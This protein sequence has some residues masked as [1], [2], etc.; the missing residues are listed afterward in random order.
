MNRWNDYAI[1]YES[2]LVLFIRLFVPNS[3]ILA[4]ADSGSIKKWPA[5]RCRLSQT[6]DRLCQTL[7]PPLPVYN[8]PRETKI[9]GKYPLGRWNLYIGGAGNHVPGYV[10]IDL[11]GAR[12]VDVVCS[13]ERLPF[14][15]AQF[16]RVEC[17]A[18]LEHV[19]RPELAVAEIFRCLQPGG[20]AHFVVP[21]CHPF[22]EFPKDYRRYTQD[23]LVQ[24]CADFEI[25]GAGWRSG[26]T[27][28]W[29]VLT[30]EYLKLWFPR[31]WQRQAVH[32]VFGWLLFPLRYLDVLLFQSDRVRQIGNHHYLYA[33]KRE[34]LVT[35]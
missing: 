30:L 28:T 20:L 25:I 23:G 4:F 16:T 21:F 33:L 7:S 29:L 11:F 26:P 13:A 2:E 15:S 32:F 35:Q 3:V 12:G 22:H 24:L 17:D 34:K 31:R 27:A 6:I 19:E 10:N 18:V 14:K 8:N 9:E 1:R 5:K